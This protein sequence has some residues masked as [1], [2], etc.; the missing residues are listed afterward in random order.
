VPRLASFPGLAEFLVLGGESPKPFAL[1]LVADRGGHERRL[2]KPRL[3]LLPV[4]FVSN[5]R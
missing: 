4:V 1:V 3:P 5:N 2:V